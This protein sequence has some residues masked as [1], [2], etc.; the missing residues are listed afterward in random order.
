MSKNVKL[1]GVSYSGVSQV[2]LK[3]TAGGTAMFKDVDEITTP[4]GSVT[5]AANGTHDVTNYAQAV[6]NVPQSGE[7]GSDETLMKV[8]IEGLDALDEDLHLTV[9]SGIKT[10]RS[11]LFASM[12]Q[13]SFSG[14]LYITLPN[15]VESI[16]SKCFYYS[17]KTIIGELPPNLKRIGGEV[18]RQANNIFS[19]NTALELPASL[20]T[21]DELAFYMY[22]GPV[23]TITFKGTPTSIASNAFQ[24]CGVTTINVPWA[25][26]AVANA[27]WG[28]TATIN[29]NYTGA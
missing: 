4:S 15:T 22:N 27:P 26:G 28:S 1:N 6:V 14:F 3:T 11:N 5:I 17:T 16:Q 2:Q 18:F 21:L 24:N 13:D 9:P 12:T 25:E 19:P 7:S 29:Y 20:E 10:L 8:L 23:K